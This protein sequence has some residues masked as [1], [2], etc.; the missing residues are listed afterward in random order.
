MREYT[1]N[2]NKKAFK[3]TVD[4]LTSELK[5]GFEVWGV[6]AVSLSL[7]TAIEFRKTLDMPIRLVLIQL[8]ISSLLRNNRNIHEFLN[9]YDSETNK[10]F[11]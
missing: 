7:R 3:R 2:V 4:F 10:C 9:F 8:V 5:Y 1:K 6:F 11:A